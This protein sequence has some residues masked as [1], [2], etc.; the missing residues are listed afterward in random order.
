MKLYGAANV[1]YDQYKD[2]KKQFEQF[3]T[4]NRHNFKTNEPI[5]LEL[6]S[7]CSEQLSL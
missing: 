4:L 7:F 3:Q 6:V 5:L 2:T 1:N